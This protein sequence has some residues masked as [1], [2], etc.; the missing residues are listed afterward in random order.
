MRKTMRII[1]D[2]FRVLVLGN[3]LC[4]YM[5]QSIQVCPPFTTRDVKCAVWL[6]AESNSSCLTRRPVGYPL[7][8]AA[9]PHK[10]MLITY[11]ITQNYDCKYFKLRTTWKLQKRCESRSTI[12][13]GTK[14]CMSKPPNQLHLPT[15]PLQHGITLL[16]ASW[17]F[18][19][20]VESLLVIKLY[21]FEHCT[22]TVT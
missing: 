18:K 7:H 6:S 17:R 1:W 5:K 16:I 22:F 4:I 12:I 20:F 13:Y 3:S 21:S 8:H 2:F 19:I 9:T 10:S 11:R 14:V 15:E